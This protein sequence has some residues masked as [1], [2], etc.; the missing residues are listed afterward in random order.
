[1]LTILRV[2]DLYSEP[3][4]YK[5]EEAEPIYSRE[6]QYDLLIISLDAALTRFKNWWRNF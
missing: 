6:D 5:E 2:I 3:P 4:T 1:M